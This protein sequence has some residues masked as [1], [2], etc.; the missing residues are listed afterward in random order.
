MARGTRA[1]KIASLGYHT[2]YWTFNT[3]RMESNQQDSPVL[4]DRITSKRDGILMA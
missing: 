1:L 4:I 2:I 3:A